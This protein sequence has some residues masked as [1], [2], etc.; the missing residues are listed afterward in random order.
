MTN[1]FQNW[2]LLWT[3]NN[4]FGK[5][6]F[7]NWTLAELQELY[8][9]KDKE[10]QVVDSAYASTQST[11]WPSPQVLSDWL[12]DWNALKQRYNTA[13]SAGINRINTYKNSM[14]A[15]PLTIV[16]AEPYYANTIIALK[17]N[18]NTVSKGDL[19]DLNQR[20]N[21]I[22]PI[23]AYSVPQ[24]S[25][26]NDFISNLS[27]TL[28]PFDPLGDRKTAENWKRDLAIGVGASLIG[29]IVLLSIHKKV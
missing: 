25:K 2:D 26:S 10:I 27:Q 5:D 17:Q 12:N 20:L 23:P 7:G 24:P 6:I 3:D 16:S 14:F 15:P 18:P 28:A 19:L 9:A 11:Q 1:R 13:K 8:D 29:G 21:T 22:K 4:S